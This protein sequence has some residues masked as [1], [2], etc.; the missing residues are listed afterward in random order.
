VDGLG[1]M[2]REMIGVEAGGVKHVDLRQAVAVNL[3]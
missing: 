3:I 2:F 1:V